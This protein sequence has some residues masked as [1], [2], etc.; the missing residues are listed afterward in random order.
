MIL[1]VDDNAGNQYTARAVLERFGYRAQLV[2][3][4]E[5]ALDA[6]SKDNF[7]LILMDCRMPIMDGYEATSAIRRAEEVTGDH[8]PIIG[9]TAYA[10]EG[11][12]E[13]CLQAGMD[14]YVTKPLTLEAFKGMLDR[15]LPHNPPKN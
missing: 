3:N 4:G 8:V 5:E 14:D 7:D 13:K 6:Y 10:F 11:D 9:V 12:R 1:V 2:S 15:W